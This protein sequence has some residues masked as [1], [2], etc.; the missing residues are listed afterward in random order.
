MSTTYFQMNL[1]KNVY[2]CG[3]CLSV[4]AHVSERV[5]RE[6]ASEPQVH[7]PII[8]RETI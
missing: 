2:V 1:Q 8:S 7:D 5:G 3:V 6:K 4:C